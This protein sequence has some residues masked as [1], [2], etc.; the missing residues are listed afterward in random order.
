[1]LSVGDLR[2]R[3]VA[4]ADESEVRNRPTLAFVSARLPDDASCDV[5]RRRL[6]AMS[7]GQDPWIEAIPPNQGRIICACLREFLHHAPSDFDFRQASLGNLV[8]G[9]AYVAHDRN[10]EPA[11]ELFADLVQAQGEVIPVVDADLHLL[12]TLENGTKL[13]GQH[14]FTGKEE[15]PVT[16]AIQSLA[17]IDGLETC[18]TTSVTCHPI[19]QSHLEKADLIV[20]PMG[21]FYSSVL[22]Q[23]LP[24]GVGRAIVAAKCPKVYIPNMGRDPEM[25]GS[26]L[27]RLVEQFVSTVRADAPKASVADVLNTV[28]VDSR[29]GRYDI[30]LEQKRLQEHGVEIVD[31]SLS[32]DDGW[33]CPEKLTGHL[34]SLV[35]K[36]PYETGRPARI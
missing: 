15:T 17:L 21:S 20:F 11:I 18:Q 16:S 32:G 5:L 10:I 22:C 3:L 12:A 6:F 9:G 1:M 7:S 24:S 25:F 35:Q 2:N 23:L 27:A 28:L 8:F 14:R 34:L 29:E 4:L 31:V 26:S 30:D 33:I 19:V 13:A 36:N